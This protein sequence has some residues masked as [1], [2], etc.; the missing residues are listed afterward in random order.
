MHA[1]KTKDLL[2]KKWDSAD[3]V[4]FEKARDLFSTFAQRCFGKALVIQQDQR[5]NREHIPGPDEMQ[6]RRVGGRQAGPSAS[7]NAI[8]GPSDQSDEPRKTDDLPDWD[9]NFDGLLA[10]EGPN[11]AD[12]SGNAASSAPSNARSS[13][14]A[15]ATQAAGSNTFEKQVF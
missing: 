4:G 1:G 13:V 2:P 14:A 6:S 3:A 5:L 12:F 9:I 8:A 11:R 10:L 7:M 15:P